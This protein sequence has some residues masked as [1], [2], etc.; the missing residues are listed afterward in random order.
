MSKLVGSMLLTA[1][2]AAGHSELVSYAVG[3]DIATD[4]ILVR[5]DTVNRDKSV[6]FRVPAHLFDPVEYAQAEWPEWFVKAVPMKGQM[7]LFN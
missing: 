4:E 6:N 1:A 7:D 5:L 3:L 2:R